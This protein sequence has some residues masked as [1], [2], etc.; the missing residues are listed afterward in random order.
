MRRW[1]VEAEATAPARA[2]IRRFEIGEPGCPWLTDRAGPGGLRGEAATTQLADPARFGEPVEPAQERPAR[3]LG[4]LGRRLTRG[5]IA[6]RGRAIPGR[7]L[8]LSKRQVGSRQRMHSR[9]AQIHFCYRSWSIAWV[10]GPGVPVALLA[11]R[12]ERVKHRSSQ[13]V[14]LAGVRRWVGR[15]AGTRA[16]SVVCLGRL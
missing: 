6:V 10:I 8:W 7:S 9:A 2:R 13:G 12:T 5:A 14:V 16:G 1:R 11:C 3:S 15:D 4:A